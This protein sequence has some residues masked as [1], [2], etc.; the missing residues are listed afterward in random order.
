MV[1]DALIR[2]GLEKTNWDLLACSMP[3]NVLLLTGYW[4]AA[5]Y[6]MAVATR[7]GRILLIVPEDEDEFAEYSW[8]DDVRTY[9]P[10]PL[11]R[12]LTAEEPV[13][14]AFADLKADVGMI[15]DRIG[16]EQ[17]EAFEPPAYAPYLFRASAARIL[18]RAFPSATL[19][20]A[21]ELLAEAAIRE[22]RMRA[23]EWK[24]R[25]MPGLLRR[26][27]DTRSHFELNPTARRGN[28]RG[29]F[30][31]N[32]ARLIPGREVLLI[33]D[34]YTTGATARECAKALRRA[35]VGKVWVATLA[36]AQ[37]PQVAMWSSG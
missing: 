13:F 19:A 22:L 29:A 11:D 5:G 32:Q 18:R 7:E 2:S 34:I 23:P 12:L 30:E 20:P 9:C 21:D 26:R 17:A 37:M 25:S 3:S 14:E 31:V 35:G 24:L 33:D 28:V 8:A 27:R 36:R 4:P 6:S 10:A 15:A 1:R 16:F